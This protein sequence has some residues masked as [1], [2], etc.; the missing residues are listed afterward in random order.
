MLRGCRQAHCVERLIGSP[1]RKPTSS[2]TL[3]SVWWKWE[4]ILLRLGRA[5]LNGIRKNNHFKDMNRIGG[6]PTEF[7]WKEFPGITTLDL[8]EKIQ[9]LMRDLQREPE[10]SQKG[11]SSCQCTTTLRGEQK[12]TKKDVNTTHRQ[13]RIMLA[14][15]FAVIGLSWVPWS[16]EKWYGTYSNRPDGSWNQSA[17]NVMA[18]FSGSGH[19]IFR[20]TSAFER[21]PLRSK[22]GGKKSIHFNGSHE[23]IELL[24]RTVVSSN[25]LSIN[26][27]RF[28]QRITQRSLGSRETCSTWS[29]GEDGNSYRHLYCR[30][31][32]RYTRTERREEI[33]T[34]VRRPEIIQ[35]V[36]QCGF[37]VLYSWNRSTTDATFMPRMCD[38]SQ[39]ERTRRRGW[40]LKNTRIGPVL[41]KK[42]SLSWCARY[43]IKVQIP[44]LFQDN[45]VS[46]VRIVNDV[47]KYV[48]ESM[49]PTKEED[50]ASVKPIAKA[51]PRQK[52]KA[53]LT[54]VAIPVLERKWVDIET[55][56]H[57]II[58]VMKCQKPS[59][60]WHDMI[61]HPS[62]KRRSDPLQLHHWRVQEEEVRRCFAM[63]TWRL[64]IDPGTRRRSED[65][66][67]ILRESKLFQSI[68]VPS[69]IQ[70]HS[71]DNAVDPTLQ[72]NELLPKGF[73]EY[74]YHIWNA[75]ELNSITRNGFTPGGTSLKERSGLLHHSEP[76]GRRI[77]HGGNSMRFHENKDRAIQEYLDT[78]SK[79]SILKFFQET[80]LQIYQRRS[81]AVVLY[82]T[83]PAACIEKAACVKTQEEVCQKVRLTPRVPR[84]VLK[85]NS[86]YCPQD[87]QSQE[88]RSSR[89]PSSDSESYGEP[90]NNIV[91]HEI[92]GAPFCS[93]TAEY[94]TREQSQKVDREVRE[95]QA[96]RI[97]QD[98]SQTQKINKFSKVS[99][100]LI[101]DLNNTEIFEQHR[102]PDCNA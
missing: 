57:T 50:T 35:T 91:D 75:N 3:C 101:A 13:L 49:L 90:C 31:F 5:K 68:P 83:L 48:T 102:C 97:I 32:Y 37:E 43:S 54:S 19:P 56:D 59:P 36:F 99:Q 41:H 17:E 81:H 79:Y 39:W 87:P 52:P 89:E 14:D 45:T 11:S 10:H 16:E 69:A 42:S 40:V 21:G 65:K 71:G 60:G 73:T 66:I 51:R 27:S 92:S 26:G 38:A 24:L 61:F 15:S 100:D 9:S 30:T 20:A 29:F 18:N 93:R 53:A 4:M 63:A 85:S 8:L 55:H 47:D 1:T 95:P 34:Y 82:N 86:Q 64:D 6:M 2:P 96:S 94:N 88:A 58:S 62:R 23:N 77:W 67:S 98:L 12:E 80:G 33:R 46:C 7:E 84:V 76:D 25:Q 78:P 28:M 22:A 74:I 72:D 44:S 70:G